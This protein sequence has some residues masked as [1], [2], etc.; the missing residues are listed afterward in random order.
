MYSGYDGGFVFNV[1][2]ERA[3]YAQLRIFFFHSRCGGLGDRRIAV[4]GG[5]S[6][7]EEYAQSLSGSF[8]QQSLGYL[9][10]G[11]LPLSQ[12]SSEHLGGENYADTVGDYHIC[13]AHY[14]IVFVML[15]AELEYLGVGGV[16]HSGAAIFLRV[17]YIIE[18]ECKR[19]VKIYIV[20]AQTSDI[21]LSA[22]RTAVVHGVF[23]FVSTGSSLWLLPVR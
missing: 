7:V 5:S 6:A 20:K 22:G 21:Y 15:Y 2:V 13:T 11:N 17:V 14:L 1:T 16:K 3:A 19:L 12:R 18:A 23:P 10:A 4:G 9:N 8:A